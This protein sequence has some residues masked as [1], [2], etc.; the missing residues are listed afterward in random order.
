[1][2][3]RPTW[4]ELHRCSYARRF[5]GIGT[6]CHA[7]PSTFH[8]EHAA[9]LPEHTC[10]TS[11]I[12]D[13][14]K[15]MHAPYPLLVEGPIYNSTHTSSLCNDLTIILCNLLSATILIL[16]QLWQWTDLQDSS[17]GLGLKSDSS[18]CSGGL[19]LG[20]WGLGAWTWTLRTWLQ[21]CQ[22]LAKSQ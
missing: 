10:P 17:P 16:I 11:C 15:C 13:S 18:P 8:R 7:R 22:W 1:V 21:V 20:L 14:Q 12:H 19:G 6:G 5:C 9:Q 3:G 4:P 2:I